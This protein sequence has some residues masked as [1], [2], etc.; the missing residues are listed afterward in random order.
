MLGKPGYRPGPSSQTTTAWPLVISE[1]DS[2]L[3]SQDIGHHIG[4][5]DIKAVDE[6]IRDQ[7]IEQI[8]EEH[9]DA[10]ERLA[11]L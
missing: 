10:W 7:L 5:P 8:L 9:E 3:V 11:D 6:E 2:V 1:G 4:S